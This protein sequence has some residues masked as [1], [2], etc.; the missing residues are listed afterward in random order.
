V[1][2]VSS[3][4]LNATVL[5]AVVPEAGA[6]LLVG[7]TAAGVLQ[8]GAKEDVLL[9]PRGPYLTTGGQRYLYVIEG[10]TARRVE[11]TFGDVEGQQ[12]EILNGVA[13]GDEVIVSGYQ[14]FAEYETVKLEKGSTR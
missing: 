2:Q 13:A 5:V 3:D 11:V 10:D 7:S 9:L 6:S 12:V 8:L 1:A 4:G 14:N